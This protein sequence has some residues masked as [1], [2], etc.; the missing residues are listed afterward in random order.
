MA[1]TVKDFGKL[2]DGRNVNAY[3]MTSACGI[4]ITILDLGGIIQSIK[5]P[6]KDGSVKDI[7]CGYDTAQIIHYRIIN[8]VDY[9]F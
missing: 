6:A 9:R 1:I 4:E 2:N 8:M 3:T 5:M 7:V